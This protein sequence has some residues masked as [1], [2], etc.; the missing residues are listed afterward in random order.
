MRAREP[1]E[2]GVA[3]HNGI[4]VAYEVFGHAEPTLLL[5]GG[6][7]WAH[8]RMW[9]AQVGYLARHYRV[10]TYD[11]PGNGRSDRPSERA[12][13]KVEALAGYATAVLDATRTPKAVLV[14]VSA[15]AAPALLLAAS[16][17]ARV[18]AVVLVGAGL[19]VTEPLP[20]YMARWRETIEGR[21]G[22]DKIHRGHMSEDLAD[23]AQFI[24]EHMFVEPHSTKQIEDGVGWSRE[25]TFAQL[26]A[27]HD[28]L[29]VGA[30]IERARPVVE[31]LAGQVR[32]PVLL[33]HGS[34][35]EMTPCAWS[36]W[37][38]ERF[39]WSMVR[40][41]GSGHLPM[42]RDPVRFNLDVRAFVDAV[43]PPAPRRTRWTRARS[44][45][46]RALFVS[47]PIGLGHAQ[48]DIAIADELRRL[49]PDLEVEWLAQSPVTL[50]LEQRKERIHPASRFLA[51]ESKHIEC[52]SSEHDLHA[53]QALR[54][55][56]EILVSNFHVLDDVVSEGHYDLW[57]GDEAWDLDY[58]LHENPER[59][60]AAYCW[61]TDF[62]GY[63]PMPEGGDAEAALAAD[64]NC[65]MIEQIE[66]YR[67][68][69]DRAIFVGDPDDI[70]P[71]RFGSGLPWIRE[72]TEKH[73]QFAGYVTGFAPLTDRA[74]LRATL[75]YRSDEQVCVVAVGGSGVGEAL[76][77]KVIDSYPACKAK[78]PALRMVVVA[79]PRIDPASLPRH[80]GLEI[81]GYVKELY[82]HLAA[83]DIALV[84]GGLTTSMELTANQ[85][86]FLYFP[87][88]EHFEQQ[89]HVP[90]R[91][92]RY[93]AGQ[94]MEYAAATPHTIAA[95][96]AEHIGRPVSY[97][98][99]E[100][101]GAARAARL[102][103]EML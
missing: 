81:R 19:P 40:Y 56:D 23:A 2:K 66:R 103:A 39:G 26:V 28:G 46:K 89:F 1:D 21:T 86:P 95:A 24:F 96:V 43:H 59:K 88:A 14:A 42:A 94:R 93:G 10:I 30:T 41:E 20:P 51:S 68:V 78:L 65:E 57:I 44:R 37:L 52:E 50:M 34:L 79:G 22:W 3:E 32:C 102:I 99:V 64:Y 49:H 77:R 25:T 74:A 36:E 18:E 47:S 35:D 98:P 72:W 84:Q 29:G 9:K 70:V 76:L 67:R 15:G 54:R 62:V 101:D 58:F 45:P 7:Q 73:Y 11:V 38:A 53:F 12:A 97:R 60:R 55:M 13:Y 92:K 75:G 33:L 63:V 6:W 31:A 69:R 16:T 87:L 17:P 85:R 71:M 82:R 4:R 90:H 83:C 80:P 8:S 91:L 5:I 100:T 48:R 61:L 27:H